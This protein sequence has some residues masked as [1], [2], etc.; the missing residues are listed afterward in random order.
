MKQWFTLH[1]SK[2]VDLHN[3]AGVHERCMYVWRFLCTIEGA[4]DTGIEDT[5]VVLMLFNRTKNFKNNMQLFRD[6]IYWLL[7]DKDCTSMPSSNKIRIKLQIIPEEYSKCTSMYISKK[8]YRYPV[9][10]F[11]N[12]TKENPEAHRALKE[13]L[14]EPPSASEWKTPR[15]LSAR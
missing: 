10:K 4:I 1:L 11:Q 7:I 12:Q 5:C 3:S 13:T 9:F 8:N 6:R 2:F 15:A 14:P